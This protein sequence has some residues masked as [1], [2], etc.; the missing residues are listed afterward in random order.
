MQ[1][2]GGTR[3]G[4]RGRLLLV[5]CARLGQRIETPGFARE[6]LSGAP[7]LVVLG[8][9][10]N[11]LDWPATE[12]SGCDEVVVD[13][14]PSDPSREGGPCMPIVSDNL[15]KAALRRSRSARRCTSAAGPR[16]CSGVAS[17][18]ATCVASL[19]KAAL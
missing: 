16:P 10:E 14:L 17:Y 13:R 9:P 18:P 7:G 12:A 19:S 3:S 11:A 2:R 6:L 4:V 15:R 1:E 5:H 8:D